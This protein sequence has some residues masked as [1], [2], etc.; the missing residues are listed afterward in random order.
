MGAYG[1]GV[2]YYSASFNNGDPIEDNWINRYESEDFANLVNYQE[3]YQPKAGRYNMG[4]V[5]NFVNTPMLIKAIEQILEWQPKNIQDYCKNITDEAVNTLREMGCFIEGSNYRAA[6]LF[7]IYVPS[8]IDI[9]VLK[10][11]FAAQKIFVSFRGKA[12][13]VAPH[14]YNSK[15]DFDKLVSCFK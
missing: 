15:A 2:A 9:D 11:R 8:H 6:H 14:V 13:R 5:S 7:G 10:A 1:L 4:E 3:N 12:I